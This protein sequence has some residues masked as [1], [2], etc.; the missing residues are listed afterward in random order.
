MKKLVKL[1]LIGALVGGIVKF[2]TS[3]KKDFEGL[4]ETQAR[5]KLDSKLPAKMPADKRAEVTDKVVA[6]M[7]DKGVLVSDAAPGDNSQS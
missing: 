7:K 2:V 1:A 3:T 5:I 4:T 6:A